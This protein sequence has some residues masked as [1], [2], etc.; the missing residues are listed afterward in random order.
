MVVTEALSR[1][2]PV[3]AAEVGGLGEA[4]GYGA[5]GIRPGLLVEPGDSAAFAAALR[6]WLCDEELR[7]RL[8][9][10]ARERRE[11]LCGW[12]TTASIIAGVLAR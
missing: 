10:A 5:G 6:A 1:G 8:R 2:L 12:S 3:V 9:R 11:S 7:A 4:L